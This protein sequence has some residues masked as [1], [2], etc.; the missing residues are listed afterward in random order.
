MIVSTI[1]L[2]I[3]DKTLYLEW[4]Y[5]QERMQRKGKGEYNGVGVRVEQRRWRQKKKILFHNLKWIS[6]QTM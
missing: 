1:F 4:P 2:T 6:L 5:K 3:I